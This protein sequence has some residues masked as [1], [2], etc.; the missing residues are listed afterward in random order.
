MD[1]RGAGTSSPFCVCGIEIVATHSLSV[2]A[3]LV[4]VW[5]QRSHAR[6]RLREGHGRASGEAG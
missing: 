4:R 2:M 5:G 6:Y 1:L 3:G